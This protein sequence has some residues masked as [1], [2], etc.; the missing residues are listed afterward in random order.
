V[1]TGARVI[2]ELLPSQDFQWRV[3][4]PADAVQSTNGE[5]AIETDRVY[6]PGPAEGTA[7]TRRL[8]LR[9]FEIRVEPIRLN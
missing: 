6:L 2:A 8:G 3:A 5:I 9:L 1:T 4:V 7:D